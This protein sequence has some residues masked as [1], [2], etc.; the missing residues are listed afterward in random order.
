MTGIPDSFRALVARPASDGNVN[1]RL[2]DVK[3]RAVGPDEVLVRIVAT[4]ICQSDMHY[5]RQPA[6]YGFPRVF[7]HEGMFKS[8]AFRV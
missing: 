2:E 4:G 3:L 6:A 1:L 5:A 8:E 7:G